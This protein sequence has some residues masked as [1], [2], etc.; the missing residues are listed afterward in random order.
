MAKTWPS[1]S[2]IQAVVRAL[3]PSYPVM[4]VR[5][6]LL[7]AAVQEFMTAF[8]GEV[9]YALKCNPH[10]LVVQSLYDAGIR[11]FDAASL[12][13]IAQV[14]DTYDDAHAYFMHPVKSRAVID[15]ARR[16]Y[17]ITHYVVDHQDELDKVLEVAGGGE[18]L[19]IVVRIK[20][21]PA[22]HTLYDLAAKFGAEADDAA[23]LM[24]EAVRRGHRA[25]IGFHVGSQCRF[26]GAYR[27]ALR[28]AGE[29]IAAAGVAPACIDVGGGFPAT[30][31]NMMA[32]PLEE[33][34]AAI[35]AELAAL[36]LPADCRLFAE[37]GRALVAGGCSLL[38]QVLLRKHDQLYIND[39]IYGCLGEV[40][41]GGIALPAHRLRA[42]GDGS[43]EVQWYT[44]NGPTCDSLDVL[45][46]AF[47]LPVDMREG[48]WI[49]IGCIGAYSNA[50]ASHFNGFHPDTFVRVEDEAMPRPDLLAA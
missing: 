8:P 28:Q 24:R 26:P 2:D 31:V 16:V 14:C 37:P 1:F 23:A 17:G 30:Y 20:T 32:P 29:I 10:P 47:E 19:V 11:H 36:D 22:P 33:F 27:D 44:I 5:P 34:M 21:P 40:A 15:T 42:D 9:L 38:V 3:R 49:E 43:A 50:M 13:E 41:H 35:K 18:P 6:R 4:C 45:K 7:A 12:P 39:G 25:G 46:A 48:D